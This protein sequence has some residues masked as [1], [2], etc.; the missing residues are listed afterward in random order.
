MIH[1]RREVSTCVRGTEP[2]MHGGLVVESGA[3]EPGDA[4]SD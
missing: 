1:R 2:N 4:G 3:N